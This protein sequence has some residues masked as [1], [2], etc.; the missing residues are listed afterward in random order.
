MNYVTLLLAISVLAINC[1][2][3]SNKPVI[4]EDQTRVLINGK[5]IL[6]DLKDGFLGLSKIRFSPDGKRFLVL[7]CGY[8][9]TD[10]VGFIFNA[11]GTGKRKFTTTWDWILQE[12]V[13]W[14]A[15]NR[16]IYYYRINST[17]ANPP[18]NAPKE[19]WIQFEIKTGAKSVASSRKLKPNTT[20]GVFRVRFDDALNIRGLPD[21]KAKVV[22]KI[23]SDG[24][25][26]QYTG[27]WKRLGKEVW[28]KIRFGK[29]VGWVNQSY[30]YE[31]TK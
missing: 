2:A 14:S 13:E 29:I 1:L 18:S 27:E 26:L 30:L 22:G 11:D 15:D 23:P 8:E 9:C 6:D 19:G 25:G 17:G 16:L 28:V 7:A 4:N 5:V 24:K 12:G 20:Y 21:L 3:Q 31:D 10:N